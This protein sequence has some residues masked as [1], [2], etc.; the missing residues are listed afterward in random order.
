MHRI[1]VEEDAKLK[2]SSIKLYL[3]SSEAVKELYS[4]G[5]FAN[6]QI[7]NLDVYLLKKVLKLIVSVYLLPQISCMVYLYH[8]FSGWN[9]S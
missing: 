6:S 2:E 9:V 8:K 3:A 7:T 4:T 5:D 1:L